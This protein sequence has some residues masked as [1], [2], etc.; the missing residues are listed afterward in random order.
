[1]SNINCY[2]FRLLYSP[3]F[4]FLLSITLFIFLKSFDSPLLCNSEDL[5][6]LKSTLLVESKR[7][8]D[9]YEE[10][11]RLSNLLKKVNCNSERDPGLEEYLANKASNQIKLADKAIINIK[12]LEHKIKHFDIINLPIKIDFDF[13]GSGSINNIY[14]NSGRKL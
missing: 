11:D 12:N 9:Y 8:N 6:S 1:M 14:F 7:L 2:L 13:S 3:F 10:F 4:P 5:D